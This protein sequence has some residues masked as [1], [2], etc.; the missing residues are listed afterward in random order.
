MPSRKSGKPGSQRGKLRQQA[1]GVRQ[2]DTT[3]TSHHLQSPDK[4]E[5]RHSIPALSNQE[6]NSSDLPSASPIRP[7]QPTCE[8]DDEI[9]DVDLIQLHV[10]DEVLPHI[11]VQNF[12]W[13]E[14][15]SSIRR[16]SPVQEDGD[17]KQLVFDNQES[18]PDALSSPKSGS[19]QLPPT[20]PLPSQPPQ[21][22][23]AAPANQK[24]TTVDF[25]D[26]ASTARRSSPY[27][28]LAGTSH[29]AIEETLELAENNP[30][31]LLPNTTPDSLQLPEME[32]VPQGEAVDHLPDDELYDATPPRLDA[33]CEAA[34]PMGAQK[35]VHEA[36][37]KH[38]EKP[39]APRNLGRK[40]A[41]EQPARTGESSLTR[42]L[43]KE[44][45]E[46]FHTTEGG[47]EEK[48]GSSSPPKATSSKRQKLDNRAQQI[49][50]TPED[51]GAAP[52]TRDAQAAGPGAKGR[53]RKQRAKP[54]LQFDAET[55]KIKEVP[56]RKAVAEPIHM[57]IVSK[58]KKSYAATT[59]PASSVKKA[60]PKSV[61]KTAPK[62]TRKSARKSAL[63][64]VGPQGNIDMAEEESTHI[65]PILPDAG[66]IMEP[67][68]AV[69]KRIT[70]S[71]V[72][73]EKVSS[74]ESSQ[75]HE[76][77]EIKTHGSTQDPIVVSS[78]PESSLFSEDDKLV[79]TDIPH[80]KEKGI[81]HPPKQKSLVDTSIGLKEPYNAVN[82]K[83]QPVLV[84]S[85]NSK[86]PHSLRRAEEQAI[87]KNKATKVSTN[88]KTT[89]HVHKPGQ[90]PSIRIGPR[91]VLSARDAN[92]LAQRAAREAEV[93]KRSASAMAP[94]MDTAQSSR[95]TSKVR[96]S[97]SVS[98]AGSPVLVETAQDRL[99]DDT[100]PPDIE[101]KSQ[102]SGGNNLQQGYLSSLAAVEHNPDKTRVTLKATPPTQD[103]AKDANFRSEPNASHQDLHAQ[104]LA[105]LQGHDNAPADVQDGGDQDNIHTSKETIKQARYEQPGD[106]MA[107]RLHG[108]VETMLSHLRTK[109]AF[110]Y[111]GADAYRK[112]GIECV[113]TIERKYAYEREALAY[114]CKKDGDRKTR[115]D[116]TRQLEETI[117]RRR[118]LFQ[119]AT[120]N[121]RALHGQLMKPN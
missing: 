94:D 106:E 36:P 88:K 115:D 49:Q 30:L 76:T 1:T 25:S 7:R 41:L 27:I 102:Y 111:A 98:Q 79:P 113:G 10:A 71:K 70:R 64:N 73:Q 72:K 51:K 82:T 34:P 105:S 101:D 86:P 116:A 61:R 69:D 21:G 31:N 75:I 6:N 78:D 65:S 81:A 66:V 14:I 59:S 12:S 74:L 55:M 40:R 89:M 119:Q 93:S 37:N 121:L 13:S 39:N 60:T 112:N 103:Q 26:T 9:D 118:H 52:V 63:R 77:P 104:I 99:V 84:P 33:D 117:A 4:H 107:E 22:Y 91:E 114:K 15:E 85:N 38:E 57:P 50:E 45:E 46:E 32:F 68:P 48:K 43:G 28:S 42:L 8:Y 11:P 16:S 90:E 3:P 19:G 87:E 53:K 29:V 95:K 47:C 17:E 96:R 110:V 5:L 62:P 67:V 35:P 58:L 20:Q 56:P 18:F 24:F 97:F 83:D 54:P 120:T 100:Q 2:L 44:L 92:I 80:P 109:E 108:L 23:P